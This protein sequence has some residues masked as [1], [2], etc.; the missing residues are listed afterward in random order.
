[1][2]VECKLEPT[3]MSVCILS[4]DGDIKTSFLEIITQTKTIGI[5]NHY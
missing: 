3:D 2:M 4:D 1:M 5:I